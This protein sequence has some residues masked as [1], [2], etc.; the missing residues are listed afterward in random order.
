MLSIVALAIVLIV[1]AAIVNYVR[2]AHR[3]HVRPL[4]ALNKQLGNGNNKSQNGNQYHAVAIAKSSVACT[5]AAQLVGRRYLSKEAPLLPLAGCMSKPCR[6][7]Y[8]HYADRRSED[9]RFPFGVR[10]SSEPHVAGIER[11][12]SERRKMSDLM[13]G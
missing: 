2:T 3:S 10:R 12:S 1:S 5:A 7:R 11:R 4:G 6:C 13:L 9:R 8:V